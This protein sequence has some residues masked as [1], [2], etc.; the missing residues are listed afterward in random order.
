MFLLIQYISLCSQL[1]NKPQHSL[2]DCV[3]A[4]LVITVRRFSN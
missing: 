2:K 1:L 4:Y 3:T